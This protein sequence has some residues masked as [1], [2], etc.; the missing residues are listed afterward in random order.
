MTKLP[1]ECNP[2]PDAPHGFDRNGSLNEDRYVCDCESWEADDPDW[3]RKTPESMRLLQQER[4]R[5]AVTEWW[6]SL[7]ERL[8]DRIYPMS[9]RE[10]L[11]SF[12]LV[13]EAEYC[14]AM[15]RRAFWWGFR[16]PFGP[17]RPWWSL[18]RRVAYLTEHGIPWE[19]EQ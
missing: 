14:R 15:K 19:R 12:D 17:P 3:F 8:A 5:L 9:K 4:R 6:W 13:S 16:H 7:R 11:A 1:P 18:E 2:H 10:E